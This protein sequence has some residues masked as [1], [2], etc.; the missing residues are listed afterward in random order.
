[1]RSQVGTVDLSSD[2][3]NLINFKKVLNAKKKVLFKVTFLLFN[4]SS[5]EDLS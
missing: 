4:L 3:I 5:Y 1:M 2:A